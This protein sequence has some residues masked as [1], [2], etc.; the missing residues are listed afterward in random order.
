MKINFGDPGG[1]KMQLINNRYRIKK[2]YKA[3]D[4]STIFKVND[5]WNEN[6][7]LLLKLFNNNSRNS[8]FF[9]KFTDTFIELSSLHHRGIIQNYNFDIVSSI[10]NKSVKAKQF[11]YTIDFVN[12][13]RLF[14]CIGKLDIDQILL[15]IY[16][17]LELVSYIAFRG[18]TYRYINPDNIFIL[19]GKETFQTKLIDFATINERIIKNFYSDIYNFFTAPEVRMKNKN[20]GISSDIYSIGMIFKYLLSGGVLPADDK[21]FAISDI[22]KINEDQKNHVKELIKKMVNKDPES[23]INKT[24]NIADE[25]NTIFNKEH[26]LNLTEERNKLNFKN[27]I[28]GRD[29]EINSILDIDKKLENNPIDK[30]LISFTGE[31]GIGK[32]RLLQELTYKLKMS[33]SAVYH[34]SISESTPKELGSIIKI[35]KS[36]IKDCDSK[37]IDTYGCEL[38]KIIPEISESR[39][40]KP[41]SML[42]GTRERLRLYDR[43]TK[44]IIENIKNNPTYLIFDNLHNCDIET[45]NLINYLINSNGQ[46]PL[47]LIVS[48][49]QDL[50]RK[51]KALYDTVKSWINLHKIEEYKLLRLNLEETSEVIK[52]VLGIS[53]RPI[54]FSTRVMN[55]TLGNP[56]HIEEAIKN[57]VATGELFINENGNWD[58]PTNNYTS[59]YI[60]SNIGDAIRR[61]IRLLDKELY[62]T[63]KYISI[64]NTSV[65]KNIIKKIV[66]DYEAD[67]DTLIDKLVSMKILDERVEDWGYTY[68]FYNRHIKHFIYN[69][70]PDDEKHEL[71]RRAAETLE[72]IYTQQDRGN[73]DELIFHYNMSMQIEKAIK[74][75]ILNA[76]KMRGLAGNIQCIH[77]WEN[78]YELMK[79]REDID[80]LEVLSNLGSL[81]LLQGMTGKSVSSYEEGL[82]IATK[83]NEDRY[84]AICNNGL[85]SA[86]Y[87]RYDVDLSK[88]YAKEAKAISEK[89]GYTEELLESIRLINR[90]E[91]SKGEYDKVFKNIGK[92]LDMSV[93]Q[94]FDLYSGHFYN[95]MGI[96]KLFTDQIDLARE[97]FLI[98]YEHFQKS[99]DY[100]ESTRALNNIGFIYA[101]YLDDMELAMNYYEEGL[102]ISKK[103][104]SLENEANFL[105]N[106][107][108]LHIRSNNYDK[109]LEYISKMESI[110]K[111][112]EDESTLFLAQVNLGLI[113]L[114]T[115]KFDKCYS[116]YKSVNKTFEKGSVEE[117]N[118]LR[119]YYFLSSF[120]FTFGDY[121]KALS[122]IND[123][124]ENSSQAL[125]MIKLDAELKEL[126]INLWVKKD[127][128]ALDIAKIRNQY[129]SSIYFGARRSCLLSLAH[130]SILFG[131]NK[132]AKD[133]LLEDK[134]LK[135]TFS[136]DYLDML[137]EMIV[138]NLSKDYN[139]LSSVLSRVRTTGHYEIE[140]FTNIALGDICLESQKY[141]KSVNYYLTAIDMLY[142]LANKI[143]DK[144]LQVAFVNKNSV[145]K[146]REKLNTIVSI[147]KGY[148]IA[149]TESISFNEST[150]LKDYFDIK[151]TV[152]L[153]NEDIFNAE[154]MESLKSEKDIAKS[155]E[156]LILQLS[157]DYRHNL[158]TILEY[159][160]SKTFANRGLILAHDF[161]SNKLITVASTSEDDYIPD[162]ELIISE[163]KQRNKGI[164][165]NKS[166]EYDE[167]DSLLNISDNIKAMICMPIFKL[168]L[169]EEDT[170]ILERR[171][172]TRI[173]NKDDIIGYLYLDTD[174][175]FNK[176]DNKR[177]KLVDSI[178]HLISINIDNYI[179][180][181]VSSIDKLTGVYTRKYF[182]STF[183]DFISRARRDGRDFSLIMID[184]DKFKNVNDTFGHRKGDVLLGKIGNIISECVRKSDIIGRYGGEEFIII[185]P[186]TLSNEGEA[187]AE[188]IREA[189]EKAALIGEDYPITI[190]LGISSFPEHGQTIDELIEKA[191]QA[192]YVAKESGRN[193]SIIW[194]NDIGKS[195]R[196]LDKLAGIITGNT[197]NDQ[198]IGLVIV[199]IIG[200]IKEKLDK[201]D[202]VFRV[203]GRMIEILEAEHGILITLDDENRIDETYGRIRFSDKWEEDLDYNHNTIYKTINEQNGEFFI[204][205]EDIREIDPITGKPNWKSIIIVPLINNG[206]VK[207]VLQI[208]VPIKEKEFDYNNYNFVN[209]IGG[210]IAAML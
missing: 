74:Q 137:R 9:R 125:N 58:V 181:I 161:E 91:L 21:D 77:L 35:L 65:S 103:Y 196:R 7:E 198:R 76:K 45:I 88:K 13:T 210:I 151:R 27:R 26:K 1:K 5:L 204:D 78:A 148:E 157:N 81:Y 183:L 3:Y 61:Q 70:I 37:L 162:K 165:I 55:D 113:Y 32:T 59:L 22:F 114:S 34:V 110:S 17:L 42:S 174:K 108:E 75:T 18:Y 8:A 112:I 142:R 89:N 135:D 163:I 79:D 46:A 171:K 66:E 175:L 116:Y 111:D 98:S 69:D 80:K 96:T 4:D 159:G 203:L 20:I 60:P 101:D 194:S 128:K 176:F 185:L 192:L 53:Y 188:K 143:S 50:L 28:I 146:I 30:H 184:I 43:I 85:S 154:Y 180:K 208:S 15:V 120:Y 172:K 25:I 117:Q 134:E 200:L 83:L 41:S 38:V 39:D 87:R 145:S 119:Y 49:N 132:V 90:I 179:L 92:Y 209:T 54:N 105:N 187:I 147:V 140:F 173:Q 199:E 118:I 129:K 84:V 149:C 121:D 10:D 68:D 197:V 124:K 152:D 156:D 72:S 123:I 205:W 40:V 23:R 57:L 73:I 138:G 102:E 193:R 97:Y 169:T 104:Q 178:S 64:F 24:K 56:G 109:A 202:K 122:Y 14:D 168:Q 107:G 63:A 51:K 82:R 29:K 106:I 71:H 31:E 190:S 95:H 170:S 131:N 206:K 182:D 155:F 130:T 127:I 94:G 201:K 144:A 48:Y 33:G 167:Q 160:V 67:T 19:E 93:E 166:F 2:I 207:G 186:D 62:D 136:T 12:G 139:T 6:D 100:V 47:V 126:L 99:G 11:Y 153:F 36:M 164:I 133:L 189:I 16:Q 177:F 44:F 191:D 158:D 195:K 150:K 52:N 115:G 141:Y 86:F